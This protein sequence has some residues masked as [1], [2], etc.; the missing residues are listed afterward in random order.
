MPDRWLRRRG[1]CHTSVHQN[2]NEGGE[3]PQELSPISEACQILSI[4]QGQ[5]GTRT[6][7]SHRSSRPVTRTNGESL[8]LYSLFRAASSA[9]SWV[10]Q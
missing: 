1:A 10:V 6:V 8:R 5:G 9:C 7:R 3:L 4:G 2:I